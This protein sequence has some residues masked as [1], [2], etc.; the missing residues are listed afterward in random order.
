MF[1]DEREPVFVFGLN[2]NE[3]ASCR[4]CFAD[5]KLNPPKFMAPETRFP[6]TEHDIT[7][8]KNK[9]TLRVQHCT[10]RN[11]EYKPFVKQL[12]SGK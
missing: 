11:A 8:N 9:I 7:N 1:K 3:V 12:H 5:V 4:S 10:Q 6:R 2:W